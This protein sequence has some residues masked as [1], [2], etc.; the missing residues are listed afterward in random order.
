MALV[1]GS[2]L[3]KVG[4]ILSKE[5]YRKKIRILVYYTILGA[6]GSTVWYFLFLYFM[7]GQVASHPTAGLSPGTQ[8][9]Y[10]FIQWV[11]IVVGVGLFFIAIYEG[12]EAIKKKP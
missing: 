2:S 9:F 3:W 10:D 8:A 12:A 1:A 7:T 4:K 5:T 6:V 11:A